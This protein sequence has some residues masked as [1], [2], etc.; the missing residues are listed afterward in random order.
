LF[1]PVGVA[2]GDVDCLA[3]VVVGQRAVERFDQ[4]GGGEVADAVAGVDGGDA[5][6]D[7]DV[8]LAGCRQ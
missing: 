8:G 6:R 2:A 4:V 1:H 7:Q 3:D 5:E